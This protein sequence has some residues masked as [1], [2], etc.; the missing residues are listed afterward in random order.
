MRRT[1]ML[2]AGTVTGWAMTSTLRRRMY[3]KSPIRKLTENFPRG[4]DNVASAI[5]QS[6]GQEFTSG[7]K[8]TWCEDREI[9]DALR[10]AIG[11]ARESIHID[12]YIWKE[13]EPGESMVEAVLA[14]VARGVA[15]RVMV[16]PLGSD[17]FEE[18]LCDR[19]RAAGCEVRY[20]RPPIYRPLNL[21]GRNHRK[22]VVIDGRIGFTGGFGIGPEWIGQDGERYWRDS[23]VRIEGPVVRQMQQAFAAHWLEVGGG[24]IPPE[25]LEKARP[26]GNARACF[27]TSTDVKGHSNARWVTS[28]VMAAAERQLWVANAYFIPPPSLVELLEDRANAGVDTRLLLPSDKNDHRWIRMIQQARYP[29]LHSAGVRVFEFQPAMMHAKTALVDGR[30]IVVGS[31]NLDP[32]SQEVLEEGSL[33]IDDEATARDFEKRWG[34]DLSESK[35]ILPPRGSALRPTHAPSRLAAPERHAPIAKTGQGRVRTANV[36][37]ARES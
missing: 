13:G 5:F 14:A 7:N 34:Q 10:A 1:G 36:R 2:L 11:E 20:F 35:E 15:V 18:V 3:K 33:L 28:I 31:I 25:E 27:V 24:L 26:A 37:S 12:V 32:L 19:L 29:A 4:I 6:T 16:D 9:F 8:V 22:L 21:L 30:L 23:N 17:G